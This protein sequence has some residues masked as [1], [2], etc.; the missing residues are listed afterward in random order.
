MTTP[1]IDCHSHSAFSG[2]GQ[3]SV[4]DAVAAAQAAG[5]AVYA[6][7]EHLT[8]PLELD[9]NRGD[10]MSPQDVLAYQAQLASEATRLASEQSPMR[11]VC[12]IEA[13]W[14]PGREDELCRLCEPYD[15]VIGSIHFLDGLALDNSDDMRLWESLG[16]DAVWECYLQTMDDMVT[17]SGPIRCLAHLDLPK[18]FGRR[19]SFD[20]KDAFGDIAQLAR[21]RDLIIELNC[22]GWLKPAQEQYPSAQI[23]RLFAD[24]GV[25]CTVG[26]DAHKPA[27]VGH[28]VRRAYQT[29]YDAG[30]R[31]VVAPLPDG[32]LERF[33][34]E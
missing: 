23:L 3:G 2:H 30:Y 5:L 33:D 29:L 1:L 21:K 18:V 19:P 6:Q 16:T 10:S 27:L 17:H 9:P 7:T 28:S 14:L 8:L 25:P 20:T 24:A 22:A 34:L 4:H 26:C 15:Y 13:D 32:G 12:G 31:Y 11:L